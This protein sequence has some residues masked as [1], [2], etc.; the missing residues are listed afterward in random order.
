MKTP[1]ILKAP[2]TSCD[3]IMSSLRSTFDSLSL[4][5][6]TKTIKAETSD[7]SL[8]SDFSVRKSFR[9]LVDLIVRNTVHRDGS[10]I[11]NIH[12]HHGERHLTDSKPNI[13]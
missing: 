12:S 11:T 7:S 4:H 3:P 13:F 8:S 1:N 6:Y 2:V 10:R 9:S 5:K